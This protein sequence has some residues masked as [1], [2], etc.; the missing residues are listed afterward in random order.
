M[1]I[2]KLVEDEIVIHDEEPISIMK[3]MSKII[4]KPTAPQAQ[5]HLPEQKD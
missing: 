5:T 4:Y 2:D 3:Q 1:A